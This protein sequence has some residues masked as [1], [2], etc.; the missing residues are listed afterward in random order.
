[1]TTIKEQPEQSAF[2]DT[3]PQLLIACKIWGGEGGGGPTLLECYREMVLNLVYCL[4]F[5]CHICKAN[6]ILPKAFWSE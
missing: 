6:N 4:R 5:Y 2:L 1:M 3:P